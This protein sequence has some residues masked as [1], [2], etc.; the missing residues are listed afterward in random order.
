VRGVHE[1]KVEGWVAFKG[2]RHGRGMEVLTVHGGTGGHAFGRPLDASPSRTF[3]FNMFCP[4][5]KLI[6]RE[7]R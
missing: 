5:Q 7:S 6:G 3:G 4:F 2:L 1:S